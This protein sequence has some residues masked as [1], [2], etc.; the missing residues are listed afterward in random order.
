M[1]DYVALG[2]LHI[3]QIVKNNHVRYSGSPI[4][5]SFSESKNSQKINLISF[6]E[7]DVQIEELDI[8][9]YR[10]LIVIK[11]NFETIKDELSKIEDKNSWIEVHIQDL[12]KYLVIC[13]QNIYSNCFFIF[14]FFKV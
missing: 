5:L 3:N 1:F 11:G 10:K 2:H 9:L 6:E 8:P 12:V 7:N 14:Y 4:P 13:K